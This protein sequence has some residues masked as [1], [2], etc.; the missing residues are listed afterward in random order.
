MADIR[1]QRLARLLVTYS[2]QIK[3]GDRLAIL[4]T[5]TAAPLIREVYREALRVGALPQTIVSLPGLDE[6]RLREGS[7]E[8]I[9]HIPTA[10][11]EAFEE[12]E[13]LLSLLSDENT[14]GLSGADPSRMAVLQQASGQLT[15]TLLQRSSRGDSTG[16]SLCFQPTPMLKTRIC[17]SATSKIS[18]IEPASW[19][20]RIQLRGGKIWPASRSGLSSG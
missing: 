5:P 19:T 9:R 15:Q 4:A 13:A 14:R 20:M 3:A 11:R 6:I 2:L 18:S 10:V 17:R 1:L 16:P 8:Q 7:D 12:F